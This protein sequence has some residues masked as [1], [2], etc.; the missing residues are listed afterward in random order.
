MLKKA[1]IFLFFFALLFISIV[2][3]I[4]FYSKSQ[5]IEIFF[6]NPEDSGKALNIDNA[7]N[8]VSQNMEL[9]FDQKIGQ[10]FIVGIKGKKIDSDTEDFIKSYHPGGV[11]LLGQNIESEA[12]LK[13]LI[14]SL[15]KIALNDTGLPLLIAV[16]QEG[17]LISRLKWAEKT[18]QAEIKNAAEAFSIAKKRGEDLTKD[19]IDL[20]FSPVLDDAVKGDFVYDRTFQRSLS[21]SGDMAKSMVSGYK[22]SKVFSC[23]KHFPG[24]VGI[25]F[26]PEDKLAAIDKIPEISQ[27]KKAAEANPEFIMISNVVYKELNQTL[28]FSF[29]KSGID[30]LKTNISGGYIVISDDLSQYSTINA[31]IDMLIFSNWRKDSKEGIDAFKK[32]VEEGKVSQDRINEAVSKIVKLKQKQ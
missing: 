22:L 26:N 6:K 13:D 8:K 20:N 14:F 10:L 23:L 28:P 4:S 29:L 3:A 21:E 5:K 19:Y 7:T 32:A 25:T 16:D 31:G 9:T 11:L 1:V 17:G 12:Q 18:P 27:F 2:L 30:F 24:Y 15:Q